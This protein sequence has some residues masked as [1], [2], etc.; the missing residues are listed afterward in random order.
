MSIEFFSSQALIPFKG[1]G[2]KRVSSIRAILNVSAKPQMTVRVVG[3]PKDCP[4]RNSH[5]SRSWTSA[6]LQMKL[7]F[8]SSSTIP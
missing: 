2:S 1:S 6:R 8:R 5:L 7:A 3:L 4:I